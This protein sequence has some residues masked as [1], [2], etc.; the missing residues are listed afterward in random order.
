MLAAATR[1]RLCCAAAP[2][3]P[4]LRCPA[5][6][7]CANAHACARRQHVQLLLLHDAAR[8]PRVCDQQHALQLPGERA[9]ACAAC[10]RPAACCNA[11]HARAEPPPPPHQPHGCASTATR[12]AVPALTHLSLCSCHAR[13]PIQVCFE[14]LFDSIR[15]IS[16]L[17][18][19]HTIHQASTAQ[20]TSRHTAQLLPL[21]WHARPGSKCSAA[22]PPLPLPR[23]RLPRAPACCAG[24]AWPGVVTP[25]PAT[26]TLSAM[27]P[28]PA[29]ERRRHRPALIR[30]A[31]LRSVP[32]SVLVPHASAHSPSAPAARPRCVT[33]R[34]RDPHGHAAA[35]PPPPRQAV[36]EVHPRSRAARRCVGLPGRA[37][38][39]H[40]HARGVRRPAG[41]APV[42]RCRPLRMLL[43]LML[44]RVVAAWAREAWRSCVIGLCMGGVVRACACVVAAAAPWHAC[45]GRCSCM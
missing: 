9:A 35:L 44:W 13:M 36:H 28:S 21:P 40:A 42:R 3:V 5:P 2:D 30:A 32:R 45:E 22:S 6:A 10:L 19:G 26:P 11:L 14:Y 31:R 43:M 12:A 33:T 7:C 29:R 18:C 16:V 20:H 1:A 15:P 23:H 24:L 39:R 27:T 34:C 38:A 25:R 8:Q 4:R 37:A 17:A 41:E